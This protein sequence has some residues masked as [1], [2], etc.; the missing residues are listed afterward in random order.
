GGGATHGEDDPHATSNASTNAVPPNRALIRVSSRTWA[1]RSWWAWRAPRS[2]GPRE[3]EPVAGSGAAA[4]PAPGLGGRPG[5][6]ARR[7]VGAHP[8]AA[9]P[10]H[11]SPARVH[12]A[13]DARGERGHRY[14][15]RL[16]DP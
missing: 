13:G 4:G 1:G 6:R 2:V 5:G 11:R 8:R 9:V 14:L 15:R 16:S 3:R 10:R 7:R 12:A